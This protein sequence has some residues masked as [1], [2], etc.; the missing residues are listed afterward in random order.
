MAK[1]ILVLFFI[2]SCAQNAKKGESYLSISM[3]DELFK[4][5]NLVEMYKNRNDM[6]FQKQSFSACLVNWEKSM[7]VFKSQLKTERNP[8]R[9][10]VL[11]YELAIC[12]NYVGE[13]KQSLLYT[14]LALSTGKLTGSQKSTLAYNSGLI[15]QKSNQIV[16][17]VSLFEDALRQNPSNDLALLE[18]T[19]IDL[20]RFEFTA[21]ARKSNTLARRYPT[22]NF[23]KIVQLAANLGLNNQSF[24]EGKVLPAVNDKSIEKSLIIDALNVLKKDKV[25]DDLIRT[26]K[27]REY[28]LAFYDSVKDF[29]VKKAIDTLNEKSKI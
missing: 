6:F 25:N 9:Q 3:R 8:G 17:A 15:Y 5:Q 18:L 22:S 14:D 28:N 20:N 23:I 16:L 26:I 21:A 10:A 4:N 19:F 29:L 24:I 13:Y 7:S 12:H 11:W 27:E 1:L 2:L